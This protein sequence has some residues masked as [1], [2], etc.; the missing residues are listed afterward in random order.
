[1]I[2]L[3]DE[4]NIINPSFNSWFH[5]LKNLAS[6]MATLLKLIRIVCTAYVFWGDRL[7]SI[8]ITFMSQSSHN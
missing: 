3:I 4:K 8:P 7:S 5:V 2:V 6:I 1:M